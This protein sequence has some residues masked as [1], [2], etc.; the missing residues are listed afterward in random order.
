M[1]G[2]ESLGLRQGVSV[3]GLKEPEGA[4]VG[5]PKISKSMKE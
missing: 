1:D 2:E 5:D 3:V 4:R